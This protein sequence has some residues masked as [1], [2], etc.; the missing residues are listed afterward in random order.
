MNLPPEASRA[1]SVFIYWLVVHFFCSDGLFPVYTVAFGHPISCCVHALGQLHE[2]ES[3]RDDL[4]TKV[5]EYDAYVQ[6]QPPSLAVGLRS[7]PALWCLPC[8][9]PCH[10]QPSLL[11]FLR[12]YVIMRWK[13]VPTWTQWKLNEQGVHPALPA[14]H[15]ACMQVLT[16]FSLH[17]NIS[18]CLSGDCA[19]SGI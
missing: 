14:E 18:S 16:T 7:K 6:V 5:E 4:L 19:C 11:Y 17:R 9:C 1:T 3:E 13:S 10:P 15:V 8:R 2:V 12:V